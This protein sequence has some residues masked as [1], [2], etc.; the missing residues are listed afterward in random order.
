MRIHIR[1]RDRPSD[2][3]RATGVATAAT[4]ARG[5]RVRRKG[6]AQRAGAG[7]KGKFSRDRA[8][9]VESS[10][11]GWVALP[12]SFDVV[13]YKTSAAAMRFRK[14]H[15]DFRRAESPRFSKVLFTCKLLPAN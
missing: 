1:R 7:K 13:Q 6:Q 15:D 3:F 9:H 10:S 5:D 11:Y 14:F 8:W 4:T 12:R 2:D